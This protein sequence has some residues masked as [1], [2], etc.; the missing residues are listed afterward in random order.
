M[1]G[2]CTCGDVRYPLTAAPMFEHGCH[3]SWCQRETGSAFAL[4]ALIESSTVKLLSGALATT[5]RPSS[6]GDVS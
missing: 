3:G 6:S 4:N 5:Q 1:S 2:Q